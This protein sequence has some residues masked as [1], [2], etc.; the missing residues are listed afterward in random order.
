VS[1]GGATLHIAFCVVWHM[2]VCVAMPKPRRTTPTML[3]STSFHRESFSQVGA[4]IMCKLFCITEII[5]MMSQAR[6]SVLC[7]MCDLLIVF[8]VT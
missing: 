8:T 5:F 6:L 1:K 4:S 3:V 7:C 2:C